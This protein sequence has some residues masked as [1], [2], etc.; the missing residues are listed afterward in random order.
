MHGGI[1]VAEPGLHPCCRCRSSRPGAAPRPVHVV[2]Q[3]SPRRRSGT[4]RASLVILGWLSVLAPVAWASDP[5]AFEREARPLLAKHCFACHGPDHQEMGLDLSGFESVASILG[6]RETWRKVG[7][8]VAAGDMPPDPQSS[9]FTDG[10]RN[11]LLAWIRTRVETID[12]QSPVYLDPGPP[13]LR[14][15]T[16][17]EYNNTIRDL[18]G[19]NYDA[20]GSAGIG[21]EDVVEG[22][23]NT[24]GNQVMPDVLVEKYFRAAD[25]ILKTL[26]EE[27]NREPQL[28]ALL[29]AEPNDSLS[30]REAARRI[31]ER[32][33]YRGYRRPPAKEDIE[34]LLVIV[35]QA[36]AS[37]DSFRTAIRKSLKPV[38]VSPQFLFRTER[39]RPSAAEAYRVG[40]HELSV[41]LSYFLWATMPDETLFSLA[42]AGKLGEPETLAAQV[43]RMLADPKARALTEHFAVHWLDIGR[44]SRALP[45]RK[46]F[47]HFTPSLK[48]AMEREMRMYFERLCVEDRSV[49]E[50]LDSDYT[51]ANAELASHYGLAGVEGSEMRRV[52]LPREL[53]RGGLLGMGGVLALTSHTDRTKPTSRG[54]WILDVMLGTPPSPPPANVSTFK[55]QPKDKPVPRTFREKLAQHAVDATCAGCHRKIDPLGFALENFDAVGAWRDT[56]GGDPVDNLGQL[57]GGEPFRGVEGLKKILRDRQDLF[58]RAMTV[59]LM[60]YALGRDVNYTDELAVVEV[61]EAVARDE[62]RFSTLVRGIV[63][64]RP[65]Q[66]R[67]NADPPVVPAD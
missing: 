65:F 40:D 39:D 30:N 28:R 32:F 47:P 38:L 24:V 20:A 7:E 21:G 63:T 56:V 45:D 53:H 54:K 9:G 27:P 8:A 31:L 12:R 15:L 61:C 44:V 13:L 35:E 43:T 16:R 2:V 42:D 1:P 58:V 14:Q 25:N 59:Q 52:E 3:R 66:Y 10:D 33:V 17:A 41:R 37:G 18:T 60:T 50:L 29:I 57:P 64:S 19:M 48:A 67:R 26:F 51:Y 11:R 23:A 6:G 34:P 62:Y 46:A 5:L 36:M 49:L 55:P 4:S 22:Y